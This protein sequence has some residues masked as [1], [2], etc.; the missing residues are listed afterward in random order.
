MY[1]TLEKCVGTPAVFA[2]ESSKKK[3]QSKFKKLVDPLKFMNDSAKGLSYLH[4]LNV[5]HRDIKTMII[6]IDSKINCKHRRHGFGKETSKG[7]KF[8]RY[9]SPCKCR[10]AAYRGAFKSEKD[11]DRGY[12]FTGL[13]I[14]PRIEKRPASFWFESSKRQ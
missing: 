7:W 10:P 4:Q 1:L 14:L 13:C 6:L 9:S 12:I 8:I 3:E 11:K 2:K 5:A